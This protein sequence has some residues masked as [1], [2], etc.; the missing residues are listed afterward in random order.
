[1][2]T[3]TASTERAEVDHYDTLDEAIVAALAEVDD[4]GFVDV[5][6]DDCQIND[7]GDG[8]TCEPLH[9]VKGATA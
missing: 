6:E 1:M 2:K 3:I 5:H 9:L 4:G 7:E 8:C